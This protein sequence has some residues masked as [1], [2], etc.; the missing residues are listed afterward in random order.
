MKAPRPS[1]LQFLLQGVSTAKVTLGLMLVFLLLDGLFQSLVPI[2]LRNAI[3]TLVARETP[4][5]EVWSTIRFG[6]IISCGWILSA[7]IQRYCSTK[8]TTVLSIHTRLDLYSHLQKMGL[9]FFHRNKVGD[10][11]TRLNEDVEIA[12]KTLFETLQFIIWAM[13]LFIPSAIAMFL[14]N[15]ALFGVFL[16]ICGSLIIAL[17]IC[18]PYFRRKEKAIRDQ[19]GKINALVTEHIQSMVLIKSH[20]REDSS[21]E[22][23][24]EEMTTFMGMRLKTSKLMV[25]LSGCINGFIGAVAPTILIVTGL[26]LQKHGVTAGVIAAFFAYWLVISG[27][28]KLLVQRFNFILPA[29]AS[30]DRIMSLYEEV[31]QVQDCDKPVPLDEVDSSI[32]FED[33]T[34]AYSSNLSRKV[35]RNFSLSIPTNESIGLVGQTGAGKS[36]LTNLIM[37]FYDP[38]E[39]QIRIGE[40]DIRHVKRSDLHEHIALVL[41]DPI[42]LS[43]T[44]RENLRFIRPEATEDEMIYCLQ[45]AKAWRFVQSL[46]E[47]LDCEIGERGVRLSGGQRQRLAIASAFLKNPSIMIFDEATSA[48]DSKTESEIQ[49]T[50]DTLLKG[51]TSLVVAH[52]LSTIVNCDKIAFI[53]KGQLAGYAPHEELMRTL[54]AYRDLCAKQFIEPT[55]SQTAAV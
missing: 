13:A 47:G 19:Q 52:R 30:Y 43:G 23:V 17:A 6:L 50:L 32:H 44:V 16:G 14:L 28:I 49:A 41:Q 10:L 42:I 39:G 51:R 37:R 1:I 25:T 48:L 54:P 2:A 34:F 31:P 53:E 24:G 27:P 45:Q 35:I 15:R 20:S 29:F 46:P 33:V 8:L 12:T 21:Y 11:T 22:Q 55:K 18:V 26:M 38:I 7:I 40:T 36:T 3:D 5:Q 4:N 9:D